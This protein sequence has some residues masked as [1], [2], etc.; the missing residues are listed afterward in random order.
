M[1][2]PPVIGDGTPKAGVLRRIFGNTARLSGGHGLAAVL[3]IA[4]IALA[5]R[6]LGGTTFGELVVVQ[7]YALTIAGICR[8]N[9]GGVLV[10]FGAI[11]LG[12]DRKRDFQGLLL[13]VLLL[14][15]ASALAALGLAQLLLAPLL[16]L[17]G[18]SSELE[19]FARPYL[20]IILFAQSATPLA[21]LRLLDRFD[22]VA[23]Q[24]AVLPA[25]RLL[26]V[27]LAILA[28]GGLWAVGA[29]WFAA[30]LLDNLVAWGLALRELGRRRLLEGAEFRLR[31]LVRP[32]PGLWRMLIAVNLRGTLG[33][34]SNRVATLVVGAM[35]DP[36]MAGIYQLALQIAGALER[37]AEMVRKALE[38]ELA[39]LV[40]A[41]ALRRARRAALRLS[42]AATA[43]GWP[44]L[45]LAAWFARP[46]LEFLGGPDFGE[47]GTVLVLLLLQQAAALASLPAA[48]VLV[49]RGKVGGLLRVSAT[50]RALFL[51]LL[52]LAIPQLALAGAGLAAAL[53]GWI[54]A[55]WLSFLALRALRPPPRPPTP[56][57]ARPCGGVGAAGGFGQSGAG[58]RRTAPGRR[59]PC[60]SPKP[61]GRRSGP[62]S[63]G[64][65][66]C[67]STVNSPPAG[68][69]ANVSSTT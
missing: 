54:E 48:T 35:L 21:V 61:C 27:F 45:A 34:V 64:S 44:L 37:V 39:R 66:N 23:G 1:P 46:L 59:A 33:L 17:L 65:S 31:G 13:L 41:G 29:A 42:A 28:G 12:A 25:V 43:I 62:C 40:A 52:L 57:A 19:A 51:A 69:R 53:A 9:A 32:H 2:P 14:D 20:A 49:M 30:N 47:G 60:P 7:A 50:A 38:P 15:L 68:C 24:R 22:L 3:G 67:P 55:S 4:A 18:W 63:A 6:T 58:A 5:A 8:F 56:P 26:G 11:C 16:P 10:R 36:R